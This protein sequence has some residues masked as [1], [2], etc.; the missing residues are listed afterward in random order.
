M[1]EEK[2]WPIPAIGN[3]P[4]PGA[5]ADGAQPGERAG[6]RASSRVWS[7]ALRALRTGLCLALAIGAASSSWSRWGDSNALDFYQ[8]WLV[9]QAAG[10]MQPG[11]IWSPAGRVALGE[12]G[13]R[14]ALRPDS[15]G[16]MRLAARKRLVLETYSTPLLYATFSAVSTGD[17]ESDYLFFHLLL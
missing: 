5:G 6:N 14:L 8:F 7:L 10:Q 17:Y 12:I 4:Q 1:V 3:P 16:A 15:T 2:I 9:G 11:R 13:A